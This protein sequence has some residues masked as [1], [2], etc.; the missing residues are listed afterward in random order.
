MELGII[1]G[2]E[3][4]IIRAQ[5]PLAAQLGMESTSDF[6]IGENDQ[7]FA[8]FADARDGDILGLHLTGV[9]TPRT[10]WQAMPE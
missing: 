8:C 5:S 7:V 6:F 2:G 4:I 1:N 3:T 10:E 9:L